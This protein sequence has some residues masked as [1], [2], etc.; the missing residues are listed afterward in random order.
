MCGYGELVSETRSR[1]KK[2]LGVSVKSR[3]EER[4]TVPSTGNVTLLED[5]IS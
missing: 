4:E 2:L 5:F 3:Y 1:S